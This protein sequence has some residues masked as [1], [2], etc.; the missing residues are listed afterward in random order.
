[1]HRVPRGLG[2]GVVLAVTGGL[3]GFFASAWFPYGWLIAYPLIGMFLGSLLAVWLLWPWEDPRDWRSRFWQQ[4]P[5]PNHGRIAELDALRGFAV[6]MVCGCHL[7]PESRIFF[8]GWSGVDLFFVLSGYL[9]TEIILKNG[10]EAG[11]LKAFYVRRTLRIWPIY[12]LGLMIIVV[13]APYLVRSRGWVDTDL[14]YY[15]TYTQNLFD[16]QIP[17]DSVYMKCYGPTWSLAL[18]EQF[19]LFW[20]ALLLVIGRRGLPLVASAWIVVAYGTRGRGPELTTLIG[21]GD[22][23]ALGGLLA[24]LLTDR[25]RMRAALGKYRLGFA[26]VTIAALAVLV[27]IV[28]NRGRRVLAYP[29]EP[30]SLLLLL[31]YLLFFGLIGLSVCCAGHP[32]VSLLRNRWL[33]GLGVISYGVYIYHLPVFRVVEDFSIRH[34]LGDRLDLDLVKLALSVVTAILSWKF[35]EQ[36]ILTLKKRFAYARA[37]RAAH[38]SG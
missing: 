6:A 21:R 10:Q 5:E 23:L 32:A 34:R 4:M 31:L 24:H 19:Y 15:L 13:F 38:D 14:G 37:P 36:P 28:L 25:P 27:M 1:M 33:V 11:F 3:L 26:L 29:P 9:I 30:S 20:P 16:T 17:G 22:G 18:E 2:I 7:W 12:Y 35:V 8:Y